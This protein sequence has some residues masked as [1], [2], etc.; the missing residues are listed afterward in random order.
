MNEKLLIDNGSTT[1]F[2]R[3]LSFVTSSTCHKE[4]WRS[5]LASTMGKLIYIEPA[6]ENAP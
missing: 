6:E 5:E 4:V 2:I 3:S 1:S